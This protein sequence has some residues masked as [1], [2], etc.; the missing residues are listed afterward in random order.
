MRNLKQL[1]AATAAAALGF[2]AGQAGAENLDLD[3]MSALLAFPIIT[4]GFEGNPIKDVDESTISIIGDA[5]DAVTLVTVTNGKSDD[6]LLKIDLISGDVYDGDNWQSTS[7]ECE[8]TGRETVTFVVT[9]VNNDPGNSELYAECSN[10]GVTDGNPL[11]RFTN[12]AN[13]IMVVAAAD[14]DSGD[15]ISENVIFGDAIVADLDDDAAYSFYAIGFQAG[16][17]QNDGDKVYAFDGDEYAQFPSVLATNFI[18]PHG[19]GNANPNDGV[20]TELILFTL[21]GTTGGLPTPRAKLGGF[22]YNDD[23]VA[24]DFSWEFDCFDIVPLEEVNPNFQYNLET[25]SLGLGSISGHLELVPQPIASAGPDAHDAAYG[26]GNNSRKRG[27]HGWIVHEFRNNSGNVIIPE[28]QP[29]IGAPEISLTGS[30]QAYVGRPLA[31][32]TTS[33]IPFLDDDDATLDADTRN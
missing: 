22:G 3:E 15:S 1:V 10:N 25:P 17:D 24:F 27:V 29:I 7:L 2:S 5:G 6:V 23:E 14:P 30:D 12:M 33:L 18:A 28:N 16:E 32:S 9:N 8:L 26:D 4:G 21:D 13:G 11:A 20:D 19:P 31:Q